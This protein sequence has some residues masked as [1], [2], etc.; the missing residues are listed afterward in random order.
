MV[1]GHLRKFAE[2]VWLHIN[3]FIANK[4]QTV[5]DQRKW[6]GGGFHIVAFV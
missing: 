1:W 3:V 2:P 6:M 4:T 5:C